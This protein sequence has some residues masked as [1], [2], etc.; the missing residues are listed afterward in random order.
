MP[1]FYTYDV[2]FWMKMAAIMLLGLNAAA[3]YFTNTFNVVEHMGPGED[4][5]PFAKMIAAS[6]MILWFV[7]ITL[8]RYIQS[9]TN[10]ISPK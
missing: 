10:T 7:V 4:A 1:G 5:P 2:V 8:G 3:F 6:S 9:Y